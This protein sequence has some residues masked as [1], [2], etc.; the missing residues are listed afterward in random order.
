MGY[1]V[2]CG[3][4]TLFPLFY[5]WIC[6]KAVIE[7]MVLSIP[8]WGGITAIF[9]SRD[10]TNSRDGV[11]SNPF[12]VLVGHVTRPIRLLGIANPQAF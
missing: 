12:D 11:H 5:E 1:T 10:D 8:A 4:V 7:S 9:G 6:W 3:S 2:C